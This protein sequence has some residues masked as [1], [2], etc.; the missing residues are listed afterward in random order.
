NNQI[1]VMTDANRI[2]RIDPASGAAVQVGTGAFTP[3]LDG[4]D[5]G[6]DFSPTA[7]RLRVVTD[8]NRNFRIDP[9]TG[10][11]V[12][13]DLAAGGTQLDVDLA[14]APGDAHVGTDPNV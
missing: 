14:F 2:Y 13:Y 7:D 8:T 3:V 9:T 11:V 1:Y 4:V 10:N 5:V 12:D 6:I